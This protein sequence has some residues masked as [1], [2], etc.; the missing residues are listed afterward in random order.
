MHDGGGHRCEL[1]N[2][3]KDS[4]G[5]VVDMMV[6]SLLYIDG[7]S[8]CCIPVYTGA[9]V[10]LSGKGSWH[11]GQYTTTAST[12]AAPSPGLFFR[13]LQLDGE[14]DRHSHGPSAPSSKQG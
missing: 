9:I 12:W 4:G 5:K 13:S 1:C 11:S 3:T 2:S 10:V 7:K 14:I 8:V 6:T